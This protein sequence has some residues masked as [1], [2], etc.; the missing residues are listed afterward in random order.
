MEISRECSVG[1]LS[2]RPKNKG[3]FQVTDRKNK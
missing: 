1:V 2:L 3:V